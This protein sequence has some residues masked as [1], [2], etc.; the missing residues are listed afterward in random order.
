MARGFETDALF[1]AAREGISG[2]ALAVLA[3]SSIPLPEEIAERRLGEQIAD[4][5]IAGLTMA[6]QAE[7]PPVVGVAGADMLT[8]SGGCYAEAVESME[9][10]FLRN[11]WSDGLP[12]VPPT[13]DAV[14][15]M[16]RGT[17]LESSDVI[18]RIEPAGA[19]AT[20]MKVAVNA[21]MAGCLPQY[22]PVLLAAVEAVAGPRF[23]LHGV[24][25]TAGLVAPL[26]ILSGPDLVDRL[27]VNDGFGTMGPGW[28][29]N[30]TIGRA[31]RLVMINLGHGWPGITDMKT[32]GSPFK[33]VPLIAENEGAYEG[34]WDPIRVVEGFRLDHATISV[35]PAVSWQPE[36]I[37]ADRINVASIVKLMANQGKVKY[38]R[39][40]G[41]WGGDNLLL[42]SPGAFEAVRRENRSRSDIQKAIFESMRSPAHEFFEG[43][44]PGSGSGP[45]K[46]PGWLVEK[47]RQD[48]EALVPLLREPENLKIAAAGGPGP[49]MC[50]F[51]GTWGY[52]G[53]Y[54]VTK[55]IALPRNWADLLDRRRG[56]ETPV[57][58]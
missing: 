29:A 16:L 44:G 39:F 37:P 34:T 7:P 25:C 14:N 48:P 52:G 26:L 21:V 17:D 23:N 49:A 38:D 36:F 6:V 20:V 43:K 28:R 13:R 19:A 4:S 54:F 55:E 15:I 18:G 5:A 51:I 31:L 46:I 30:M 10:H 42:L 12:L 57:V 41:N 3:I 56:W 40:A 53:S 32:F 8:F 50:A 24:Q 58:K 22:M 47:C 33:H 11:R 45:N 1:S 2:L 27:N 9:G 35:M